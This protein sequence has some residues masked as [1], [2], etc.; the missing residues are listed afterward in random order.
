MELRAD[1]NAPLEH[2]C[3]EGHFPGRPILPGVVLVELIV[4]RIGRGPPRSIP[5]LKFQRSLA[6]G[7]PFTL[8]WTVDGDRVAFGCL[9][10]EER[11]AEGVL[12]FGEAG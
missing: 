1:L 8:R 12:E 9:I 6:P 2:P 3:Y 7:E 11:V 4:E 10:G 5:N